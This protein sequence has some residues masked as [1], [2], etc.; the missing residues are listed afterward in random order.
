MSAGSPP[1]ERPGPDAPG[2]GTLVSV[3]VGLP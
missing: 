2:V 1:R 3:T